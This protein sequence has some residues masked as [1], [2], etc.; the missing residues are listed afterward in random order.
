MLATQNMPIYFYPGLNWRGWQG[1]NNFTFLPWGYIDSNMTPSNK[2]DSKLLFSMYKH[3]NEINID[4]DP[5]IVE[6]LTCKNFYVIIMCPL[7]NK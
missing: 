4:L 7:N 5:Y 3:S 2:S 1:T 6:W